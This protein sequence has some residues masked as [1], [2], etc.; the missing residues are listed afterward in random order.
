[1]ILIMLQ[2]YDVLVVFFQ[3]VVEFS[4]V[5][6]EILYEKSGGGESELLHAVQSIVQNVHIFGAGEP[7]HEGVIPQKNLKF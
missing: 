3:Q 7:V 2:D 1:M 4:V 5:V 6:A